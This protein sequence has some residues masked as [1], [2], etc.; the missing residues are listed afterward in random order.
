MKKKFPLS[1]PTFYLLNLV[2]WSTC[3]YY[4][5]EAELNPI[6]LDQVDYVQP[7]QQKN[8][9]IIQPQLQKLQIPIDFY[10]D[11]KPE[12]NQKPNFF[13]IQPSS[14][15]QNSN[16]KDNFELNS[17]SQTTSQS[18]FIINVENST[19]SKQLLQTQQPTSKVTSI[20]L[21]NS[22][23][24]SRAGKNKNV[25]S[26][27][28]TPAGNSKSLM[29]ENVTKTS[30]IL[31]ILSNI[32]FI[33]QTTQNLNATDI[34]YRNSSNE[35]LTAKYEQIDSI[36]K[37]INQT[38]KIDLNT[39]YRTEHKIHCLNCSQINFADEC[40][41]FADYDLNDLINIFCCQCNSEL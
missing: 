17:Q 20:K 2:S 34:V 15:S 19:N 22:I 38:Y 4:E 39:K 13:V 23:N 32:S 16:E 7:T 27:I 24:I 25:F 37:E 3:Y 8:Q 36:I 33:Y 28:V 41:E 10:K 18:V 11:K 35:T 1:F 12:E 9:E 14:I 31:S 21:Q 29:P 30:T 40:R 6:F 5:N 26:M